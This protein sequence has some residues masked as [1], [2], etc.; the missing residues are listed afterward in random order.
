M[1]G[2]APNKK[3]GPKKGEARSTVASEPD[4]KPAQPTKPVE[5]TP[6]H[7]TCDSKMQVFMPKSKLPVLVGPPE[8][9]APTLAQF[10]RNVVVLRGDPNDQPD[11]LTCDNLRLTLVP[12]EKPVQKETADRRTPTSESAQPAES[13][14]QD[15]SD[16][17]GT[18]EP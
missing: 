12:G 9:P 6:L 18:A 4:Q 8:P 13:L 10:E 7:L 5:P 1:P 17:K 3:A 15:D 11:Q 2:P 16:S 14:A